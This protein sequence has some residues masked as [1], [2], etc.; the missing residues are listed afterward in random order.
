MSELSSRILEVAMGASPDSPLTAVVAAPSEDKDSPPAKTIWVT[1]PLDG[2]PATSKI[3]YVPANE[4]YLD[5][6]RQ[7]VTKWVTERLV[8]VPPY[9][10]HKFLPPKLTAQFPRLSYDEIVFHLVA[11]WLPSEVSVGMIQPGLFLQ[12]TSSRDFRTHLFNI[13]AP[14]LLVTNLLSFAEASLHLQMSLLL[15]EKTENS[16][17][18]RFFQC[19]EASDQPAV[20]VITNDLSCLLKQEAGNTTYG[21]VVFEG[22][23]PDAP[24]VHDLYDPTLADQ[25]KDLSELGQ[26][27]RLADFAD[28][29]RAGYP[30]ARYSQGTTEE[31]PSEEVAL[32]Q[33]TNI[34]PHHDLRLDE[35]CQRVRVSSSHLLAVGDLCIPTICRL[36]NCLRVAEV[37]KGILPVAAGAT[38]I[39]VR[40]KPELKSEDRQTLIAYLRS[41]RA[42]ARLE[43][44]GSTLGDCLRITPSSLSELPIP[45]F[46]EALQAALSEIS[47]SLRH[48]HEWIT[49]AEVAKDSLFEFARPKDD[50]AHLLSA[51]RLS[52]QRCEA[53]KLATDLRH[54]I[55]TQFPHPIAFRWRTVE[56]SRP[57]LE[58]YHNVLECAEVAVCYLAS[59]AFVIGRV[60]PGFKIRHTAAIAAKMNRNTP[61]GTAMGDWMSI[62]REVRGSEVIRN[63]AQLVAF[64]EIALIDDDTNE[65]LQRLYD[66]RNAFAH[67]RGPKGAAVRKCFAEF[68]EYLE[69]FLEGIEFVTE[70]P[71]RYIE[72]AKLDSFLQR[73]EYQ[74]RELMGDHALVPL[75]TASTDEG[76][77]EV[78]SLYLVDRDGKLLLLRPLLNWLECPECRR[79]SVFYLDNFKKNEDKCVL[80]SMDNGH[81]FDDSSLVPAFRKI[82]LIL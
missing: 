52:R 4:T 46:D 30:A 73:T 7:H 23:P 78:E 71:L 70:Y 66:A 36:G 19:P 45:L 82:G 81:T 12:S 27:K 40:L 8:I 44:V 42:T 33:A 72:K 38:V 56:S 6:L 59:V 80:K 21:Y 20:E 25:M 67:G 15:V 35:G 26:L 39:V 76:E 68:G 16:R 37:T 69:A 5:E 28:I 9:T 53:A 64:G 31:E 10:P 22:L 79:S 60:L 17:P 63:S 29:L 3:I 62:V 75:E 50:R 18:L 48:F 2:F 61:P 41:P 11:E 49:Q 55:R 65:A 58:G 51:G 1:Y 77:I 34:G 43:I 54:R 74:Y 57:D 32:V 24:L 13:V 14:K 47:N